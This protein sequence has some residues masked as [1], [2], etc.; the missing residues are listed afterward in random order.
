MREPI[1]RDPQHLEGDAI[2]CDKDKASLIYIAN[3]D[4]SDMRINKEIASLSRAFNIH[5]IG[6][7][8]VS[9]ISFAAA[10]CASFKSVAPPIRSPKTIFSL[11]FQVIMMRLRLKTNLFHVVDEQILAILWPALFGSRV[12]L[13]IFDSAFLRMDKPNEKFWLLKKFL[14]SRASRIIVTDDDRRSLLPK[15]AQAKSCVIPNVPPRSAAPKTG[16]KVREDWLTLAYFGSLAE[17]R[18]TSFLKSLIAQSDKVRVISAGWPAD[19]SSRELIHHP[20]VQHL[21][22]VTQTE[23]NAIIARRADYI[24]AVYPTGDLNNYYASPNKL[25][26]AIHTQTPLIMGD[27]VKVAHFVRENGLGI[28]L[29]QSSMANTGA[30]VE[31]L[32]SLRESFDFDTSLIETYSWERY[33]GALIASHEQ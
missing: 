11:F 23:A 32:I 5:Y 22:V 15:F 20:A 30:L 25:Y 3:N 8:M 1:H 13:D 24:V 4:G 14:Y 29:T 18:G 7:G 9:D 33:E 17:N 19:E 28:V 6:V 31:R 26:D 2:A 27:N 21:G 10:N 12:V 16:V